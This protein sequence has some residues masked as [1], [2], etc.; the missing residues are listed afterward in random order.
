MF[1][2]NLIA[3]LLTSQLTAYFINKKNYCAIR[4]SALITLVFVIPR[5]FF[6]PSSNDLDIYL[7]GGSFIGMSLYKKFHPWE[8]FFAALFFTI[9]LKFMTEFLPKIGG[10]LGFGAFLSLLCA[11]FTHFL[12]K[13]LKKASLKLGNK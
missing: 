4:A 13:N 5:T 9:N 7:F 10:I 1:Y 3:T 12:Y 11:E 6:L 2:F 8:I